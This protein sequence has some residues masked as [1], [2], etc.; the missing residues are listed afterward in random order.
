MQRHVDTL[1]E[2]AKYCR[3]PAPATSSAAAMKASA[4][5][6]S[7]RP[8]RSAALATAT[9]HATSASVA[10]AFS[11]TRSAA[12]LPASLRRHLAMDGGR[13]QRGLV[14]LQGAGAEAPGRSAQAMALAQ[15]RVAARARAVDQPLL[16][17]AA[18]A[19]RRRRADAAPA[20]A[21][22]SA[23]GAERD[24]KPPAQDPGEPLL[25]LVDSIVAPGE[26]RSSPT[27]VRA[28]RDRGSTAATP[29]PEVA[30]DV[31]PVGAGAHAT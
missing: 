20:A 15:V 25:R 12:P 24:G 1:L 17:G 11:Q 3:A 6:R 16:T 29:P 28:L 2:A 9:H 4:A 26:P 19:G 31:R 30:P 5:A 14:G 13:R 23:L 8:A 10:A 7:R 27:T 22:G 18:R 21:T